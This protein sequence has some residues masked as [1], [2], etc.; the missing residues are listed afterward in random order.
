MMASGLGGPQMGIG[1]LPGVLG[2]STGDTRAR[3]VPA[4]V[5]RAKTNAKREGEV[6]S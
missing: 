5:G 6:T 3:C 4:T 1:V 2:A